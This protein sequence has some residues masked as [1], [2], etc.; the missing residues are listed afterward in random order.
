MNNYIREFRRY[1]KGLNLK[2]TP[3]REG[4]VRE[5]MSFKKHFEADELLVKLRNRH[6]RVAKGTI[7][8]TLKLLVDAG[9]LRPV[10]FIDRHMHYE[11]LVDSSH[12]EHLIC[13]RCGRIIEFKNPKMEKMLEKICERISFTH[14]A[15]KL[16]ITGLC[17]RCKPRHRE[18]RRGGNRMR[19]ISY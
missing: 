19:G 17:S 15:H 4:I 8:R 11:P 16:E 2:C 6:N 10:I 5:V 12:H 3:E 9:F 1:L 18:S 13:M 7:Y 14:A